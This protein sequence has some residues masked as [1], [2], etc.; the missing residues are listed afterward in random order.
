M[1]SGPNICLI[2]LKHYNKYFFT[3]A[4]LHVFEPEDNVNYEYFHMRGKK[5]TKSPTSQPFEKVHTV[6]TW[7]NHTTSTK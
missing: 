1:I 6:R 2:V 5:N 7:T 4:F 3:A